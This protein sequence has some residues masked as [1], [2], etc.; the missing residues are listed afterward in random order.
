LTAPALFKKGLIAAIGQAN[1][2]HYITF[3]T[4]LYQSACVPFKA[5]GT[6]MIKRYLMPRGGTVF[7][8]GANG[9]RFTAFAAPLVGKS[10]RVY[11]FEPIPAALR[12]LKK[13]VAL[14]RLPQVVV[15]EAALSNRTSTAVMTIPLKDG[16]KPQ[17]PIAYLDG[18]P[19]PEA[20]QETVPVEQLDDFCAA[21]HIN[22]ID[23]IKCDTEGHEYFVFAG[24]LKT[25]RRD[26]PSIFCEIAKPYLARHQLDPAAVFELLATLGYQAYLPTAQGKLTP[27][28]GYREA[29]DYFF[30]HPSK[31]E[32][33]LR[34][35]ILETATPR[36]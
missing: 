18:H 14:R 26:R 22:R 15:I 1:Y 8:I 7:D 25:L 32:S 10:G 6:E 17:L 9:G 3:V 11:S 31:L 34:Q 19:Q 30:L 28:G 2:I 5:P 24:G 29:T 23:F 12:V 16:W 21:H 4:D 20:W 27:V 13:T 33:Q 35:I 36:Q